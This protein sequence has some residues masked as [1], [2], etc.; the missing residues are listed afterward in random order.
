MTATSSA[1]NDY[2]LESR[3]DGAAILITLVGFAA[4]LWSAFGTFLNPDEA[5]HFR[6]ANQLSLAEAYRQSLTAAHPPLLIL[7]LYYWRALGVS[8]LWLRLP[9]VLAGAVFC[10]MFYKWLSKTAGPLTGLIGILFVAF[11]PPIVVLFAEIRQY[12]LLLAFLMSALYF[13]DEAFAL[14][15]PSRMALFSLCLYLAMGFH[16]SAFLF[17]AAVGVYAL[18]RIFQECPQVSLVATWA[19]GQ[20]GALAIAAFFYKTHLS[21]PGG[22]APAGLAQGLM[23]YYYLRHA[24]FDPAQDN[25]LSFLVGHSFGVFQYLFGQLAV[26]DVMGLAF[27][28]GVILLVR[29]KR[30]QTPTSSGTRPSPR[31]LGIFLLLPFAIT[32]CVSLAHDYPYGGTRH[33]N[34]LMIPAMT[35][36]SVAIAHL[37]SA[38]GRAGSTEANRNEKIW[39]RGIAIAACIIVAC[40]IFG[41]LRQP[42]MTRANQ[43]RTQMTAA[44]QYLRQ[45]VAPP[46][47]IFADYQTDLVL[48]H[49]LCD[50]RPIAFDPSPSGFE[51][52]SCGSQKI[53]S[54]DFVE[55]MF[56]SQDFPGDWRH[57]LASYKL[58]SGKTVWVAQAGWGLEHAEDLRSDMPRSNDGNLKSFGQNIKIF[59]MT[60]N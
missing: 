8:E 35:G 3:S 15:S 36:V 49:Y 45:N 44:L 48:G 50:Q 2:W 40:L 53:V 28:A 30:L 9:S 21:K 14:N 11:L 29:G 57:L 56:T 42:R 18:V 31:L 13:L 59:K 33:I 10:W 60:V 24:F 38:W 7:V 22:G 16:Y 6:L 4:R 20:L 41:K 34:F 37:A 25:P 51:Q 19:I 46:E 43:S 55:W 1:N 54:T 23:T 26:G 12:P 27:L 58:I 17:A 52:F 32:A 47:I 39:A 5:L